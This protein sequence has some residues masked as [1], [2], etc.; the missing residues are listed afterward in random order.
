MEEL[1]AKW[2]FNHRWKS[3]ATV[4]II[5]AVLFC[6]IGT[7]AAQDPGA[8][9]KQVSQTSAFDHFVRGG[10]VITYVIL[11]PLSMLTIGLCVDHLV[12]IRR[13]ALLPDQLKLTL[14]EL[15]A[16]RKYKEVLE[17][18]AADRSLLAT[19][20]HSGLSR[21]NSGL[22]VME[23]AM[24]EVMESRP[25]SLF[26]RIEYLN[27][28]GNVSP[29]IGLFGTVYGMIKTFSTIVEQG[30]SPDPKAL[31]GGISIALVTTFWGLL[32]AIP[33]LS[34]FHLMRNRID[35]LLAECAVEAEGF[36][37]FFKPL[38]RGSLKTAK[39]ASKTPVVASGT[40]AALASKTQS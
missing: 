26:R 17:V 30:G 1:I 27:I 31:A 39:E 15:I 33:A 7:A 13:G 38:G 28:I 4:A 12:H 36:I 8:L 16:E 23:R 40:E 9:Q 25:A 37:R 24:E 32:V 19:V 18:T 14:G 35:G 6:I 11:L 22:P 10:G 29:M 5:T 3:F 21:A 34:V 2:G 20:L